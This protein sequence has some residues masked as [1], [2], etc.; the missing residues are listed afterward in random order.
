MEIVGRVSKGSRMDQVY[1]PKQRSGFAVGS[2]VVLR[3]LVEPL[4]KRSLYYYHVNDLEPVK[5]TIIQRV[6]DEIEQSSGG[7]ENCIVM[8]SFLDK[9]FFFNDVDVLV[10]DG[11]ETDRKGIEDRLR[12]SLGIRVH[13]H[14]LSQKKLRHCL[15]VDPM[16]QVML[17]RCVTRKRFLY[18]VKKK[19][20]YKVLDLYLLKSEV[21]IENF[22]FLSGNE[23]YD[24]VRNMIAIDLFLKSDKVSRSSV[25]KEIE[26]VFSVRIRDLKKNLVEK[27]SFLKIFRKKY[28]KTFNA[29]LN[30]SKNGSE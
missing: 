9:G 21:L 23:K 2:Y 8:G 5:V 27:R 15:S 28:E 10:V 16:Y 22:E 14:V 29:V 6:M 24:L 4:E 18:K 17:S 26:R 7:C 19:V 30:H 13:L 11:V 25:D 20:E 12:K 3:S 1:I